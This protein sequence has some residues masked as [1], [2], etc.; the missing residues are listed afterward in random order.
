MKYDVII[1][2][3]GPAGSACALALHNSGLKVAIIDKDS[4]PREKICGDA[5]PGK[6]FKALRT[7]NSKWAEDL[8]QFT[9]AQSIH[10]GHFYTD[11][12][13]PISI[14]WV[15]PAYNSKREDFDNFLV[16]LVQKETATEF[17]LSNR[18]QKVERHSDH[19]NVLLADGHELQATMLI[20]CDG[21]NSVAKRIVKGYEGKDRSSAVAVRAYYS[22]VDGTEMTGN[23]VFF[24]KS[25]YPGYVWIFPMGNNLYNVGCGYVQHPN[26]PM[27]QPLRSLMLELIEKHP[28]IA[29]KFKNA[30]QL[31]EVKGFSLPLG[32]SKRSISDERILLCDDAASLVDP[33]MGHGIDKAMWSGVLAAEQIKKCFAENR[34]DAVFMKS[35][36][37]A[38]Y[39]KLGP[40]LK[41]STRQ[42]NTLIRYPWL[43]NVVSFISQK[44][45]LANW[46][47]KKIM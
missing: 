46:L 14:Q 32:T 28:D 45:K 36:D 11:H 29:P 12:S 21:A 40:E 18:V 9:K 5:I 15:L 3:A 24:S 41:S 26:A 16:K 19:V 8:L 42:M 37:Q 2:G 22:D 25:I 4:F 33:F 34:F 1:L 10:S 6:S 23:D 27:N 31:N 47:V 35:Y 30:K 17:H 44:P 20:G 43:L 13:P 7:I 38:V 39:K